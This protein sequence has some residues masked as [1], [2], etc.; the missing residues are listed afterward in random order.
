MTSGRGRKREK[1]GEGGGE[2]AYPK[3]LMQ[4]LGERTYVRGNVA[5]SS[6]GEQRAGAVPE[7][8][9]SSLRLKVRHIYVGISQNI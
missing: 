1:R 3:S 5:V 7:L 6:K 2:G 4:R 8:M 9:K